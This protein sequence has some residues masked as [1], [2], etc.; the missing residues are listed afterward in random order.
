M[1]LLA[2]ALKDR[3]D[4]LGKRDRGRSG[5]LLSSRLRGK[6]DGTAKNEKR[7]PEKTAARQG[8]RNTS[9]RDSTATSG[10]KNR[11]E[12][13]RPVKHCLTLIVTLT[14]VFA[15]TSLPVAQ[16]KA[17]A[18]MQWQIRREASDNSQIMRTLHFLTDV[19]GPRLTGS[20][21]LKAAQDWVVKETRW[22]GL[23]PKRTASGPRAGAARARVDCRACPTRGTRTQVV[24]SGSPDGRSAERAARAPITRYFPTAITRSSAR[25]KIFPPP[26]AGDA[27]KCPSSLLRDTISNVRPALR[28]TV[29]PASLTK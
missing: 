8:H 19:Y 16:E 28:T 29:S 15:A 5:G 12:S 10:E 14:A 17:D 26:A 7:C 1:A 23:F 18:D 20:P 24:T 9:T 6:K 22:W 4:V 21:N 27:T 3:R 2:A 13:N 11:G 25:R